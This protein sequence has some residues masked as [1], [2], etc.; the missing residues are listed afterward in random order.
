MRTHSRLW[1]QSPAFPSS[2]PHS[3]GTST[4]SYQSQPPIYIHILYLLFRFSFLPPQLVPMLHLFTDIHSTLTSSPLVFIT[5]LILHKPRLGCAY[6]WSV[7]TVSLLGLLR[8]VGR[9]YL[10][11]A[12]GV[13]HLALPLLLSPAGLPSI[14]II[15]CSTFLQ[16]WNYYFLYPD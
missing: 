12:M 8:P 7:S 3:L 11:S 10:T 16:I 1:P 13:L 6:V 15:L 2:R 9:S 5:V 14:A 4:Y